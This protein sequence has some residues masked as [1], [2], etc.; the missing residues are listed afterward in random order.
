MKITKTASGK[1]KITM[2]KKEWLRIGEGAGWGGMPKP[3]ALHPS[4]PP[5]QHPSG[6]RGQ[7]TSLINELGDTPASSSDI[8][9]FWSG[10]GDFV[11]RPSTPMTHKQKR[12][13]ANRIMDVMGDADIYVDDEKGWSFPGAE[14]GIPIPGAKKGEK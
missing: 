14:K 13:F 10:G 3:S 6:E 12:D 9:Y 5:A 2:S 8:T 1:K 11:I 4:S 7:H